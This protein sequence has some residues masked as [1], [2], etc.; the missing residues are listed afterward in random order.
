ME[1]QD[2]LESKFYL[3]APGVRWWLYSFV[4]LLANTEILNIH[5]VDS[6]I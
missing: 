4:N 6:L 1:I 2:S 5:F 3:L